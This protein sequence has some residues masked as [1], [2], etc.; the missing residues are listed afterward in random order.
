[1]KLCDHSNALLLELTHG[2][3]PP[4]KVVPVNDSARVLRRW[5]WQSK[6]DP[7][8]LSAQR[9]RIEAKGVRTVRPSPVECN[10]TT[11]TI[12]AFAEEQYGHL[13]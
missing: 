1:L 5:P 9:L 6:L 8:S 3:S 13:R 7:L 11:K 10:N 2:P 12:G 4:A